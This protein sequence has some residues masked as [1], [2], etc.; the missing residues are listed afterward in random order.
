[1]KLDVIRDNFCCLI[2]WMQYVSNFSLK[3]MNDFFLKLDNK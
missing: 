2:F 3:F 1:M